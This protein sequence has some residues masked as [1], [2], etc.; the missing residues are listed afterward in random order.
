MNGTDFRNPKDGLGSLRG[1]LV[2]TIIKISFCIL[3]S[4]SHLISEICR[5]T[6]KSSPKQQFTRYVCVYVYGCVCMCVYV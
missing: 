2:Y 6:V 1:I 5:S 3:L 4:V